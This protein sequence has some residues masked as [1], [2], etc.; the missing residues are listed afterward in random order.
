MDNKDMAIKRKAKT[1]VILKTSPSKPL[2]EED[3][4]SPPHTLPKPVPL[5]WIKTARE[6]ATARII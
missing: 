5:T 4:E 2:L 3:A 6:R 1:K